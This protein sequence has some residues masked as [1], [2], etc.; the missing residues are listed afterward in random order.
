MAFWTV[1]V[2]QQENTSEPLHLEDPLT[3]VAQ[4]KAVKLAM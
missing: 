4:G 1:V 2:D 3:E